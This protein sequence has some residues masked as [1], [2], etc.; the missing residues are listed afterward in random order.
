MA[1][2]VMVGG[3]GAGREMGPVRASAA[4]DG[5]DRLGAIAASVVVGLAATEEAVDDGVGD[6]TAAVDT[7]GG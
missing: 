7:A 3:G 4:F 5:G 1:S 6:A 2:H